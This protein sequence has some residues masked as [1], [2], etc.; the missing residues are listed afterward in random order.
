MV[1]YDT[2]PKYVTYTIQCKDTHDYP[3]TIE[4]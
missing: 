1:S 3:V 2:D 4:I